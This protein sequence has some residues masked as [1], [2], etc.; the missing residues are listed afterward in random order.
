MEHYRDHQGDSGILSYEIGA[1]FIKVR[2]RDGMVYM[3]DYL[4]AGAGNIEEMKRLAKAGEGLNSFIN[5]HVG[6]AYSRRER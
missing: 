1:N 2:F 6:K 4:S 5:E 3:Y